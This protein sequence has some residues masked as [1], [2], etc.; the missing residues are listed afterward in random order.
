M[1]NK[2]SGLKSAIDAFIRRRGIEARGNGYRLSDEDRDLHEAREVAAKSAQL[3]FFG[4]TCD[5]VF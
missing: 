1:S 5:Q 3:I 4:T 2:A